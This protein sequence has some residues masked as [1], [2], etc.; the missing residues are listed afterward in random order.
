MARPEPAELLGRFVPSALRR[1]PPTAKVWRLSRVAVL[2]FLTAGFWPCR[3]LQVRLRQTLTLNA[4]QCGLAVQLLQ[5]HWPADDVALVD[6]AAA[7]M[8]VSHAWLN[9]SAVLMLAALALLVY[10]V[11]DH[12]YDLAAVQQW[13]LR[14]PL[15][16]DGVAW[17]SAGCLSAA[18]LLLIVQINRQL[19]AMQQFALAF[20]AAAAD[21]AGPIEPPPLVWGLKPAHLVVG[22]AGA[23]IGLVW[24]LPM[25]LAWAAFAAFVRDAAYGFRVRLAD[26][27]ASVGGVDPVVSLADLCPNPDC[28]H[29][30]PFDAVFCPRCGTPLGPRS[31]G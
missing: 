23:V 10:W 3:A 8:N 28:R 19:V 31:I 2:G 17:A 22:V 6:E 21:K 1:T 14:A 18:Y 20:N 9:A 16:R 25:M 7:G 12:H 5:K 27:L 29:S 11:A 15:P 30:L 13:W 4:Q 26:R 24:A